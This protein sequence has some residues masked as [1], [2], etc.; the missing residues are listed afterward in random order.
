GAIARSIAF[1][2]VVKPLALSGSRGVMRADD[3]ASFRGVV[4][5]LRALMQSPD[6]RAER[7]DAHQTMLVEGFIPGRE[8]ALEGLLHHGA[9]HVLALFDKPDPLDGPFFEET[10]YLTPSSLDAAGRRRLIEAVRQA[11]AA[12]GLRHG[13]I[14]AECRVNDDGVFVIE[15]AARP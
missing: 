5:R 13:P 7:N 8:M 12:I 15:V 10:I 1:P 14:H 4:L 3:T 9:L 6:I 11:A 2:C